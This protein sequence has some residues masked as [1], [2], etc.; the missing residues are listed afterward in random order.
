MMTTITLLATVRG[1]LAMGQSG[2][3]TRLDCIVATSIVL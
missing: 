3:L 2:R 1:L